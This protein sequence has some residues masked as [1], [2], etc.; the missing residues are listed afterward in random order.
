MSM[1]YA[2]ATLVPMLVSAGAG[3]D[4]GQTDPLAVAS[5]LLGRWVADVDPQAPGVTG[6]STVEREA[7]GRVILRKN[8]AEYP[9]TKDR[10]ASAHDDLMAVYTEQGKV[11]A[12]YFDNEGHVIRY[13]VTAPTD[14]TLVFLSQEG[15]PGPRFRLTYTLPS[16]DTLKLLFEIAPPGTPEQF[17]PYIRASL[18]R[19]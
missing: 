12:D 11:K 13:A 16:K 4:A 10:P 15:A 19:A 7:Q 6:W 9:A 8:R 2:V 17:K 3:P 14:S 1:A 5:R 18:H